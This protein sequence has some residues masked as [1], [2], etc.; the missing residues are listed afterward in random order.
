MY[1]AIALPL[2]AGALALRHERNAEPE[3]G[4]GPTGLSQTDYV[5][6][7]RD[8][9]IEESKLGA[10]DPDPP[11]EPRGVARWLEARLVKYEPYERKF[12]ALRPPPRFKTAHDRMVETSLRS[13]RE[14]KDISAA[15]EAKDTDR[16]RDAYAALQATGESYDRAA[17]SLGLVDCIG[18]PETDP[19]RAY[20]AAPKRNGRTRLSWAAY[21]KAVDGICADNSSRTRWG[22]R[23]IRSSALLTKAW[24]DGAY[25]A[26]IDAAYHRLGNLFDRLGRPPSDTKDYLAWRRVVKRREDMI[27]R[28]ANLAIRGDPASKALQPQI[29][30]LEADE[31][32]LAA[33]WGL[34]VCSQ[35][36][37]SPTPML[38][39]SP[40]TP[41]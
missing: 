23:L 22:K 9:C 26:L 11:D 15:L 31:N 37:R 17:A 5:I 38:P 28:Q 40:S 36:P 2:A 6:Q 30:Q 29:D 39:R 8:I 20:P 41:A 4:V 35:G 19:K 18:P 21:R 13:V 10:R 14:I 34:R 12:R 24:R 32:R 3:S 7:T 33:A 25:W 16:A 27:D 1:V